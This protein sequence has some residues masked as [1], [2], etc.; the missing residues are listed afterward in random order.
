MKQLQIDEIKFDVDL[1]GGFIRY[2]CPD[3]GN[4]VQETVKNARVAQTMECSCGGSLAGLPRALV[5]TLE[6]R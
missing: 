2:T 6:T 4:V 1:E 5:A 3:C